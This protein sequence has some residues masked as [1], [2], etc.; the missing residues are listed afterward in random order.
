MAAVDGWFNRI[1]QVAAMCP[2]VRAHW[3]HL[4]N[5]IELMHPSAHLSPQPKRQIDRFSSRFCTA[6]QQKVPIL[7]NG[8]P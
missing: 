8:R 5:T 6:H 4:A 2:L 1:R 3:R 7:Y